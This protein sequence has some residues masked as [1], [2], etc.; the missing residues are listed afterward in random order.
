MRKKFIY[1]VLSTNLIPTYSNKFYVLRE[2]FLYAIKYDKNYSSFVK[3][4]LEN[5]SQI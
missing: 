1:T 5:S 2:N 3:H 4:S